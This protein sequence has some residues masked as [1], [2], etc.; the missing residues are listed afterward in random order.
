MR[1]KLLLTLVVAFSVISVF[2]QSSTD[3]ITVN[4]IDKPLSEAVCVIEKVIRYT[5]FYDAD[6]TDMTRKVTLS[7]D[8]L[9]VEEAMNLMLAPS[10]IS[11][12]IKGNQIV[13]MSLSV[14][15]TSVKTPSSVTVTVLDK[16]NMPV[17]GAAVLKANGTGGVTDIDGV[18]TVDLL[19][20]DKQLTLTCLGYK[21][22]VVKDGP[23]YKLVMKK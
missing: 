7:S 2:A 11:F 16:N 22:E 3:H 5:F 12:E 14:L 6:K 1:R 15:P 19:P 13:L 20:S 23:D 17:I 10:G 4:I 8:N 21:T 9:P 18:C